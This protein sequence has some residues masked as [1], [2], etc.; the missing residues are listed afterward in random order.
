MEPQYQCQRCGET[1]EGQSAL[2]CYCAFCGVHE[3]EL[4]MVANPTAPVRKRPGDIQPLPA[5]V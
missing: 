5:A 2:Q 1:T 4:K 3:V